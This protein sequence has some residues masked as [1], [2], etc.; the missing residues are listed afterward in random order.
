MDEFATK[1]TVPPPSFIKIDAEG[2]E[3]AVLRGMQQTLRAENVALMVEVTEQASAVYELLTSAGY[4]AYSERRT[5]ICSPEELHENTFWLKHSD[6]RRQLFSREPA[7]A[8][9]GAR[10]S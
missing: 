7:A 4:K 5:P 2:S 8:L 6:S 1:L 9:V 3:L 10:R